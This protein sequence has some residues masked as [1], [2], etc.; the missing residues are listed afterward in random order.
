MLSTYLRTSHHLPTAYHEIPICNDWSNQTRS[1]V[2]G[3]LQCNN[4]YITATS[5]LM[6]TSLLNYPKDGNLSGLCTVTLNDSHEEQ[7]PLQQEVDP[8]NANLSRSFIP[9]APR[10]ME[11]VRQLVYEHQ[12]NQPPQ[13]TPW[14]TTGIPISEFTIEGYITCAFP[15][16]NL[17]EVCKIPIRSNTCFHP[18]INLPGSLEKENHLIT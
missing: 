5:A 14:P 12:S 9:T 11:S 7:S 13:P 4:V 2:L 18:Y 8:Y 10:S 16:P 17:F 6:L 3:A 1:V 15:T